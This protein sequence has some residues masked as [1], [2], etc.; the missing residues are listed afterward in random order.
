MPSDWTPK[1][2]TVHLGA[3]SARLLFPHLYRHHDSDASTTSR[4]LHLNRTPPAYTV[5]QANAC[6]RDS[7]PIDAENDVTDILRIPADDT[8]IL[9]ISPTKASMKRQSKKIKAT[10]QREAY[11]ED[12]AEV[13]L[14]NSIVPNATLTEDDTLPEISAYL[15]LRERKQGRPTYNTVSYQTS[16][17]CSP[18]REEHQRYLEELLTNNPQYGRTLSAPIVHPVSSAPGHHQASPLLTSPKDFAPRKFADLPTYIKGLTVSW[19]ETEQLWIE[20]SEDTSWSESEQRWIY[21][22][23]KPLDLA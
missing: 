9:H 23:E 13:S 19:S 21:A 20:H 4:D 14:I 7:W 8:D 10:R 6:A 22:L 2:N 17:L 3:T 5:Q 11:F 1:N 15:L 16:Y 12:E 18:E